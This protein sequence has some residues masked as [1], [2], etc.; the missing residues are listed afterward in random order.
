[1]QAPGQAMQTSVCGQQQPQQPQDQLL[2]P[3]GLEP[4]MP[5]LPMAGNRAL[6]SLQQT[7]QPQPQPAQLSLQEHKQ[8]LQTTAQQVEDICQVFTAPW[9][10]SALSDIDAAMMLNR[11]G[12][13]E[14]CARIARKAV[15]R[16]IIQHPSSPPAQRHCREVH[17]HPLVHLRLCMQYADEVAS[18]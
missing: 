10:F 7:Q 4:L 18:L 12:A 17:S 2:L 3:E 6:P 5:R 14:T 11:L 16:V 8:Q 13:I 15:R 1:M 9:S